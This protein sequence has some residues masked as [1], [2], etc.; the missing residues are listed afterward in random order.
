[1]ILCPKF[2]FVSDGKMSVTFASDFIKV[3]CFSFTYK[4]RISL[5]TKLKVGMFKTVSAIIDISIL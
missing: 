3:K 2:N 5:N 4:C 1:M